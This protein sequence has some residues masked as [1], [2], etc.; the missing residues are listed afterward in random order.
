MYVNGLRKGEKMID[1]TQ[2]KEN[3]NNMLEQWDI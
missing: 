3:I 1:A 2:V